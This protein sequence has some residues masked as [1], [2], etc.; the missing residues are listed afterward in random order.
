MSAQMPIIDTELYRTLH[1]LNS[2]V[3][4]ISRALDVTVCNNLGLSFL[5]NADAVGQPAPLESCL[6]PSGEV[7]RILVDLV[8]FAQEPKDVVMLWEIH[9][10]V[11]HVFVDA[12]I[13]RDAK[14][15][16]VGIYLVLKDLGNMAALEQHMLRTDK[17]ATVGKIAAGIA[18]E[19]RNPLT[20]LKGF[21]QVFEA[22]FSDNPETESLHAQTLVMLDEIDRVNH[23][24]SELLLLSKPS[25]MNKRRCDLNVILQ[26]LNPVIVAQALLRNVEFHYDNAAQAVIYADANMIKQVILNLTKNA[27]EA[28]D[29]GGSLRIQLRTVENWAIID[30]C[31][32]GPGIPYYQVDRIFDAFYTTKEK[33]TGLGLPICQTII[34]SHDGEIRVASKGF[35]TTFSVYLPLLGRTDL[36]R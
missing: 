29:L 21:L 7:Y 36:P 18:H 13:H 26:E 35:G 20:T 9:G 32:S 15:I 12:Y 8:S 23:L 10:R 27:I 16:L 3:L 17:L 14:G 33:G 5:E 28:M 22:R 19:I 2:G 1:W 6:S 24:V 11:R 31:D 25:E 34:A 30:V 4:Y